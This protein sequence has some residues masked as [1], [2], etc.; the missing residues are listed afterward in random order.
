[1]MLGH[2]STAY[3]EAENCQELKH[4]QFWIL[5]VVPRPQLSAYIWAIALGETQSVVGLH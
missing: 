1:M 2:K 5:H 4:R 3:I